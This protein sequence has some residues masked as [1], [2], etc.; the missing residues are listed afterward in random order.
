MHS[1]R[2]I[3]PSGRAGPITSRRRAAATA[4]ELS[5]C[6]ETRRLKAPVY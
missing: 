4:D 3:L 2:V 6:I 1:H 5:E